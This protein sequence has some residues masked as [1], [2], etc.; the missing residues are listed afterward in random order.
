MVLS[1]Q[2]QVIVLIYIKVLCSVY[3]MYIL[4]PAAAVAVSPVHGLRLV[5]TD[6][7]VDVHVNEYHQS[8]SCE[9]RNG[10][11]RPEFRFC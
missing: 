1:I 11:P 4:Y 10:K 8:Q 6:Q 7:L 9:K 2:L 5:T 3:L